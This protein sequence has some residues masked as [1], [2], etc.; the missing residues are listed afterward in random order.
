MDSL[1]S[2]RSGVPGGWLP[3][4]ATGLDAVVEGRDFR[5]YCSGIMATQP[6]AVLV[7]DPGHRIVFADGRDLDRVGSGSGG[8]LVG[9]LV[10]DVLHEEVWTVLGSSL[11]EGMSGHSITTELEFPATGRYQIAIS[12]LILAGGQG[13]VVTLRRAKQLI[14]EADLDHGRLDAAYDY[15]PVGV[16]V[17]APDARWI[18]VNREYCE[19]LGYERSELM[20]KTYPDDLTHPD[21]VAADLSWLNGVATP[22][23]DVSDAD[24]RYQARDGSTVWV[25]ARSKRIRNVAGDVAY[26]V[27]ALQDITEQRTAYAALIRNEN[28]LRSVIEN[29]PNAVSVQAHDE[30]YQ[31]VNR[32]FRERFEIA[33]GTLPT[34]DGRTVGLPPE[35]L[36]RDRLDHE[37]VLRTG[38]SVEREDIVPMS[39]GDRVYQTRKFPLSDEPGKVAAVCTIYNDVTE[40]KHREASLRERLEWTDRLHDAAAT[41]Q[42]VLYGQPI[43]ELASGHVEQAELLVRM[44]D[45]RR[46]SS[47]LIMPGQ[48]LPAA[49]RLG[50][51]S[52]IDHWVVARAVRLAQ[53]HR[54]EVNISAQTISD[55]DQVAALVRLVRD[56][57][58][59]PSNI[60][61]EITET[62]VA[63]NI[64]SA[65]AFV[66]RLHDI[67]CCFALDDFGTGFG[68]FTYLKYLP[69]DYL[70]I[71]IEFV[72]DLATNEDDRQVVRA[73]VG[74]AREYGMRTV[75]EGVEDQVTLETLTDL[76]VDYAQGYWIGR[77]APIVEM[78]PDAT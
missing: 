72:R 21:D 19:M 77:P 36:T 44:K 55:P 52:V 22:G 6:D 13:V 53:N 18:S 58:A 3:R 42:F 51:A 69:V 23:V 71:D 61:F 54:V 70:K 68:T 63:E 4:Q 57:G 9:R 64:G 1:E 7:A 17:I 74:V 65:R 59:P 24:R 39:G 14:G 43:V 46:T 29:T 78:W 16:S 8:G 35:L 73:I 47:E 45:R 32:A 76:D 40:R 49:E 28:L 41:D 10:S 50:L 75:A 34:G 5:A 11:E 30:Q 60:I 66:T 12:P 2:R 15:V 20:T 31:I 56:S 25:H 33:A 62:A 27:T 67:G 26:T 48:F 37:L 38:T